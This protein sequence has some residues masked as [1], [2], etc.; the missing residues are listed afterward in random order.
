[1]PTQGLRAWV[2]VAGWKTG[3]KGATL[4]MRAEQNTCQND[5]RNLWCNVI[6]GKERVAEAVKLV[7]STFSSDSI[8]PIFLGS[9]CSNCTYS[10]ALINPG[11]CLS[12]PPGRHKFSF[13]PKE[14]PSYFL[15]SQ[16]TAVWLLPTL[17]FH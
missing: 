16:F 3:M 4:T 11:F 12:S 9:Y 14:L 6:S 7:P 1:M 8:P 15:P 17:P 2:W 5:N 10:P 13:L